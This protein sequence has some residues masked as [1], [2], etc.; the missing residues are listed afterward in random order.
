M[1]KNKYKIA[2]KPVDETNITGGTASFTPGVG[3]QYSTPK[4][5]QPKKGGVYTKKWGYKLVPNKIKGSGLEVKKLSESDNNDYQI[6]RIKAFDKI[7]EEINDIYKMLSNAKNET[8]DFYSDNPS[9]TEPVFPTDLIFD[10]LKDIKDI[11]K[12]E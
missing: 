3:M 8:S 5:F 1:G 11:L 12:Q 10:Y 4:A 6:D 7:E 2:K 9:S